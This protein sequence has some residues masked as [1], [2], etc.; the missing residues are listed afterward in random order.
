VTC[1]ATLRLGRKHVAVGRRT[2]LSVRVTD[3]RKAALRSVRVIAHGAGVRLSV[4]TNA[5]G[6][7]RFTIRPLSAGAIRIT[8]AQAPSCSSV[9]GLVLAKVV[10]KSRKPNFTG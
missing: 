5:S 6:R 10:A 7:A 3:A 9:T 4:L 1:A 8:V 2:L